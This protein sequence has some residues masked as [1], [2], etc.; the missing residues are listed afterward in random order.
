[1]VRCARRTVLFDCH[2]FP[3][4]L[5]HSAAH[6]VLR[7]PRWLPPVLSFV[8]LR[9]WR[10]PRP[11]TLTVGGRWD[12]GSTGGGTT[13]SA[14]PS[15]P[16]LDWDG[17]AHAEP[18]DERVPSF[19]SSHGDRA[20]TRIDPLLVGV[21]FL[22]GRG[23]ILA[24][25]G[26]RGHS[27]RPLVVLLHPLAARRSGAAPRGRHEAGGAKGGRG[28]QAPD[29]PGLLLDLLDEGGGARAIITT[30]RRPPS[31]PGCKEERRCPARSPRGRR[32]QGGARSASA[33][34]PR[35]PPRS[36]GRDECGAASWVR[37]EADVAKGGEERHE[38]QWH[39]RYG[40]IRA[41]ASG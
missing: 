33:R 11:A 31:S 6:R 13:S 27:P 26:G 17:S 25:G 32:G 24:W 23:E 40:R 19:S 34:P 10:G 5:E 3:G 41:V 22:P 21:G 8:A 9:E 38:R 20:G 36:P 14:E 15:S 16:L 29:P 1:M 35:L 18:G 2:V 30:P 37:P 4:G 28:A 12:G 39:D 7:S